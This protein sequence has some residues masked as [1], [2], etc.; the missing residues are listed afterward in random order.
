MINPGSWLG[1]L[2]GGQLGRMFTTAA[3]TMGYKVAVLDPDEGSPA[4]RV[5]EKH[6]VA[7]YDDHSALSELTRLT[8]VITTEFENVPAESL[9]LLAASV[10]TRPNAEAV[11]VAQDRILEKTFLS[12]CGV[13][14]APSEALTD[15]NHIQD[16][17]LSTLLPG[18]LKASRF[19]Y[20]GKGQRSVQT[21]EEASE[22]YAELGKVPCVLEKRLPLKTEISVVVG[23]NVQGLTEIF[24]IAENQHRNGILDLSIVPAR[25]SRDLAS[26]A[27]SV[28]IH[29]ARELNYCGVLCVEFFVLENDELVVNE[30][31]PRP[32]NSGHYT[33]DACSLSQFE[34][35][36]RI[37]AEL[38]LGHPTLSSPAVM[39][40]I[41]GDLWKA[42][43]PNWEEVVRR[44]DVKLHL[45]GKD[46]PRPGRK[47][48][49]ITALD[50][51]CDQAI[52]TILEIK[53]VLEA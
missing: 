7:Q 19:G 5:A 33:I 4:G 20:D 47:M 6:I 13:T 48:G 35:Q 32:H 1:I 34:Q 46:A 29:I 43:E 16:S 8:K 9:S 53:Q 52:K 31:A 22:A 23:R 17:E 2:G 51:D 45:Y 25:I 50:R 12:E 15:Q 40:N 36:V 30:I 3:Q 11:A 18:I 10:A 27:E 24:P 42:G 38:P 28:A 44:N 49:H 21:V 41:L 26:E 37:L 14:V 39:Y